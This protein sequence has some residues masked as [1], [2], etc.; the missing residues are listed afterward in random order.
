[1]S[2]GLVPIGSRPWHLPRTDDG[3]RREG[4]DGSIAIWDM[5]RR[6]IE[7]VLEGERGPVF[8]LACS[9]D[10]SILAAA[11]VEGR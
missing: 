4:I 6:K 5:T 1:M 9:P 11:H 2:W 8:D 3:W 10:G 7:E